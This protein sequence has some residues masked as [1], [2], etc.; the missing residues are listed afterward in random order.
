MPPSWPIGSIL[1]RWALSSGTSARRRG[2]SHAHAVRLQNGVLFPRRA[3]HLHCGQSSTALQANRSSG[4]P[5]TSSA[6]RYDARRGLVH[7][8]GVQSTCTKNEAGWYIDAWF[9]INPNDVVIMER[10][11]FDD[12][13]QMIFHNLPRGVLNQFVKRK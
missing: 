13:N 1:R 9:L 11:W 3:W 2:R 10:S 12:S 8:K 6:P 5:P 7:K 4:F